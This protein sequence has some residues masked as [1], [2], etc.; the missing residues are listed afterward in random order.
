METALTRL[1]DQYLS[2]ELSSD[3]RRIFEERMESSEQLRQEVETQRTI[4]EA[5]KR[6][7]QRGEIKKVR[8]GYH[9]KR[10]LK[11]SSIGLSGIAL[12]FTAGYVVSNSM[13]DPSSVDESLMNELND[14]AQINDLPAQYFAIPEEGALVMSEEGVLISVPEGAF[15][16]NGKVY[17]GAT[18]VQFQEA[19]KA[20]S[21]VKAGLST[22]SGDRLLETQG[23]FGV[24]GFTE[25]GQALEF[26]PK[27]G[28]YIQVPVDEYKDGMQLFS[29]VKDAQGS[30]DWQNP[31]PLAKIPVPVDMS[32]LDFY[33]QAYEPYLNSVQWKKDKKSRDS[34]YLSFDCPDCESASVNAVGIVPHR[35]ITAEESIYLYG[36]DARAIDEL[37]TVEEALQLSEWAEGPN[38]EGDFSAYSR[39]T[40]DWGIFDICNSDLPMYVQPSNVLAFWNKKFNKTNLSTR[41][42]EQRMRAIHG[43]CNNEV[44]KKY[45]SQLRKSLSDIDRQVVAM[46]YPEFERFAA[47]NLAP[48]NP[49]NAHIDHL[50]KFYR[51]G[52]E[53]LQYRAEKWREKEQNRQHNWDK[54][55]NNQRDK[56]R[57]RTAQRETDV[58]MEEFDFNMKDVK[59]QIGNSVGFTLTH[60]GG[61]IVNIDKY[62]WDATVSRTSTTITDPFTGKTAEIVYKDFS[63]EVENADKYIKL[64]AY[65]FPHELNS[66]HRL[67][68]KK[69]K[70]SF[71]LNNAILYDVAVVG[72]K[73][74]GYD[75]FQKQSF[76]QG[77]LGTVR[78]E[79]IS[80]A[81][82][83]ASIEQLNK[84]RNSKAIHIS[85]EI[86]WLT[87]ERAD[88]K[89]QKMRKE[90]AEFRSNV[91]GSLFPCMRTETLHKGGQRQ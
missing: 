8:K 82:M 12:L 10:L 65:V 3:D 33:P 14:L 19:M 52:I 31:V 63:F 51:T 30:I 61:T 21:I 13:N 1:I 83:E 86:Q 35:R 36:S 46:G 90:M 67:D 68:G 79:H 41:E 57:T 42:F 2:G 62:V 6:A 70:F 74:N 11:W 43:T 73:E 27:V 17:K 71:P 75:Y 84:K 56:E 89:E 7:A 20:S 44:L 34:L 72:V 4:Q 88:Y 5:A 37:M 91:A 47:E 26:N 38:W 18:V 28:V 50:E 48:L 80:E 85:D 53:K 69:G 54:E 45:T 64:F 39:D 32:E 87:R 55:T 40:L 15:L 77:D 29:G 76:R 49:Q 16:L 24:A 25:E 9:L 58:L 60:G 66:Y 81:K 59:R 78:L 22:M 23:M